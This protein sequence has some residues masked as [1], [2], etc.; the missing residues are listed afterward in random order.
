MDLSIMFSPLLLSEAADLLQNAKQQGI[1]I[2]TVESCT[3]GLVAALLTEI[4]GSSAVLDCGL[5]TYSNESKA[6]LTEVPAELIH[7]YGA[8]S[9]E[10]AQAMAEGGLAH[11]RA[12]LSVAVTGIAGPGG[13]S[14]AKPVGTV[15]IASALAGN[16]TIVEK[17]LFE[18]NRSSVR[19]QTV[20]A[21]LKLLTQQLSA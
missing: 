9:E 14:A 16:K 13:G 4:A 15:F 5:I 6:E 19:M 11:S 2:I 21:A 20:H 1:R 17:H 8:V 12:H 10:V 18:G 3:G 7:Q